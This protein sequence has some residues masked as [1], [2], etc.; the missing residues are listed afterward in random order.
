[1][2]VL[3]FHLIKVAYK[4][5]N[6]HPSQFD[7]DM[8]ILGGLVFHWHSGNENSESH[9]SCRVMKISF[10]KQKKVEKHKTEWD[11]VLFVRNLFEFY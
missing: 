5:P 9:Q 7:Q 3:Y 11:R 2:K 1:M 10:P 8:C 6:G 4:R